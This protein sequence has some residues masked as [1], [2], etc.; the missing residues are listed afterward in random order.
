MEKRL[1][2]ESEFGPMIRKMLKFILVN[3]GLI[4]LQNETRFDCPTGPHGHRSSATPTILSQVRIRN[5]S[6]E[7]SRNFG[8]L[9]EILRNESKYWYKKK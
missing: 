5:I 3:F 6:R 4:T 8:K 7:T 9:H 2:Y 1:E